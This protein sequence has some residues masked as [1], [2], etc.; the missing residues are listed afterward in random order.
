MYTVIR[1]YGY[2]YG[3]IGIYTGIQEPHIWFWPTLPIWCSMWPPR[4]E[5]CNCN[6][7]L[8]SG[9]WSQLYCRGNHPLKPCDIHLTGFLSAMQ[10]IYSLTP[11]W[12]ALIA[13]IILDGQEQVGPLFWAGGAVIL[14]ASILAGT[15]TATAN[16]K[17][18][19][20]QQNQ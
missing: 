5:K 11:L 14:G 19:T 15:G 4:G 1:L 3:D 9:G 13:A 8:A 10:V 18:V 2:I 7:L 17:G 20:A 12:S 6:V 16:K